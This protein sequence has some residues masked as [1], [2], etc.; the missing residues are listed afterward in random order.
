MASVCHLSSTPG[1]SVS[2]FSVIWSYCPPA[3]VTLC[4]L[5]FCSFWHRPTRSLAIALVC[6]VWP[7]PCD[8]K[9]EPHL[10]E[11]TTRRWTGE[12]LLVNS[13]VACRSEWSNILLLWL[14]LLARQETTAVRRRCRHASSIV[15]ALI[16]AYFFNLHFCNKGDA[17]APITHVLW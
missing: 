9:R 11:G 1:L 6:M 10:M 5:N 2:S 7:W 4:D 15:R 16:Y 17:S 3:W 13:A 12:R 8:K 14:L